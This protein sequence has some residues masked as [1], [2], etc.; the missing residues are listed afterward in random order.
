M[1]VVRDK[2]MAAMGAQRFAREMTAHL[3]RFS[4]PLCRTLGDEQLGDAVRC[5]IASA[6]AIGFTFRGPARLYLELMLLFGSHFSTDPQYS[7]LAEPLASDSASD[8]MT[9]AARLHKRSV[10]YWKAVA[11]PDDAYAFAALDNARR[12][13]R[14]HPVLSERPL[15]GDAGRLI[16]SVY[17][18]KAAHVRADAANALVTRAMATAR[19]HRL[20]AVRGATVLLVLA[21]VLGHRCSDDPLYPWIGQALEAAP[22]ASGEAAVQL[23]EDRALAWLDRVLEARSAGIPA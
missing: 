4:G 12:L 7:W 21:L 9:R 15:A 13:I 19:V 2:Q 5:G 1:L 10:A 16:A 11:G 22:Q 23:L 14:Q 6:R 20:P 3:R 18:Q 8:Q 17:P